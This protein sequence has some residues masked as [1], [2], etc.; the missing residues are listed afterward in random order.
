MKPETERPFGQDFLPL[1]DGESK[2]VERPNYLVA[3]VVTQPK[4]RE[5]WNS[6]SHVY[7]TM[8]REDAV[9]PDGKLSS[10]ARKMTDQLHRT[11]AER[12]R[13]GQVA[14]EL[15]RLAAS[16]GAPP[17]LKAAKRL[18]AYNHHEHSKSGGLESA[19]RSMEKSWSAYR[20]TAHLQAVSVLDPSL[21]S[22]IFRDEAGLRRFLGLARGFEIFIDNNIGS[23]S[24]KWSPL[25][26]PTEIAPIFEI[27]FR[28][29]TSKELQAAKQS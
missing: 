7:E 23:P 10:F 22:A 2:W 17:S 8:R 20:D 25:R 11:G 12:L 14:V 15:A 5:N 21:L 27:N 28:R 18:A 29:L 16:T 4:P 9:N 1:F 13:A 26:I 3:A 19:V 6:I 24:L